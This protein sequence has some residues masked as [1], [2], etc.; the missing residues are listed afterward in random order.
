MQRGLVLRRIAEEEF[1]NSI[2]K[3]TKSTKEDLKKGFT[4][5]K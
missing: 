2:A 4:G 5:A 1:D 3:E